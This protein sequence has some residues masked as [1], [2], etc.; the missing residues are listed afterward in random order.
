[1]GKVRTARGPE[2]RGVSGWVFLCLKTASWACRDRACVKMGS[3][4]SGVAFSELGGS[5]EGVEV[6]VSGG[7]EG[8][9]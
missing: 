6:R 8:G 4:G 7:E 9:V 1:M 2:R 5:D 3:E